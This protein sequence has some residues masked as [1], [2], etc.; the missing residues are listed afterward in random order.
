[1]SANEGRARP[2][3][4]RGGRRAAYSATAARR[5][6]VVFFGAGALATA[7]A[8]A[9]HAGLARAG[10]LPPPPL[11]GTWCLN[12]KFAFLRGAAPA[13]D[14]RT[15]L[16]VGSSATWRNLDMA[17]LERRLP[18]ARAL[19][20]A[21]CY[22]QVDQ[23][24]FLAGFLLDRMPRVDTV[25]AVLAPRDFEACYPEEATFF[26]PGLAGAYLARR[27]PAWLPY[28]TGFRPLWLMREALRI[29]QT[30]EERARRVAEDAYGSSVLREP[31]SYW[32]A[33]RFDSRC[34]AALAALEEAVAARGARLVVATTPTMPA[35]AAAFDP[36]G[37]LMEAWF[38]RM[39]SALRRPETL[40]VDGRALGW[41]DGRF[42]DPVHL[43][44]P[45]HSAY[46]EFLADALE[47]R[48]GRRS[49]AAGGG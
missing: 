15:V 44:H 33:P 34:D 4:T 30:R 45:H 42:A 1:M 40:L 23:T 24:A 19:N 13:F 32:P 26:D 3:R 17:A 6:L 48:G 29:A 41:D 20:A 21:P 35:W 43:L 46:T 36:D 47:R 11:T 37:A 49:G 28:V 27:A 39:A 9:G 38:R 18:G 8:A 10:L 22:L 25:L 2:V 12:E 14:D 7:A 16:A 5:F 31:G